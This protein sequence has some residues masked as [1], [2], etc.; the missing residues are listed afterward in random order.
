MACHNSCMELIC[1]E[2]LDYNNANDQHK[3]KTTSPHEGKKINASA[4]VWKL[5]FDLVS[6]PWMPNHND[7]K[8]NLPRPSQPHL[9]CLQHHQCCDCHNCWRNPDIGIWLEPDKGCFTVLLSRLF[10]VCDADPHLTLMDG[11]S[12]FFTA[13]CSSSSTFSL[14]IRVCHN[15]PRTPDIGIWLDPVRGSCCAVLIHEVCSLWG[16]AANLV[17]TSVLSDAANLVPTSVFLYFAQLPGDMPIGADVRFIHWHML[18]ESAWMDTLNPQAKI[19]PENIKSPSDTKW[20]TARVTNT[21]FEFTHTL[22]LFIFFSARKKH[23]LPYIIR[24]STVSRTH[25]CYHLCFLFL[26]IKPYH[27][28][29]I[30]P[31]SY[32]AHRKEKIKLSHKWSHPNIFSAFKTHMFLHHL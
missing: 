7:K 26:H 4:H 30:I 22:E 15:F 8:K 11:F 28:K 23:I 19:L 10:A 32:D 18:E 14:L 29:S 25:A 16:D 6:T 24:E 31:L 12:T 21:Q 3:K 9:M 1:Y 5:H 17:P 20:F 2:N 27:V 13:S